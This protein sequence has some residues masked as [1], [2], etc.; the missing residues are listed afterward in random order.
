MISGI[1]E[2]LDVDIDDDAGCKHSKDR[3]A[4]ELR[5]GTSVVAMNSSSFLHSLKTG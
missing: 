2:E 1:S 3:P 5:F 4:G